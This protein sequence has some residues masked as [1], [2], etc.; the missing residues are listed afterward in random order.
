MILRRLVMDN[1][2]STEKQIWYAIVQHWEEITFAKYIQQGD[3]FQIVFL[4]KNEDDSIRIEEKPCKT[5][6]Q[7]EGYK[8]IAKKYMVDLEQF[9]REIN[10]WY[11]KFGDKLRTE[12]RLYNLL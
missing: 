7:F 2:K 3:T 12:Q 9:S 10:K 6:E 8:K 4:I 1:H 5:I 11:Q